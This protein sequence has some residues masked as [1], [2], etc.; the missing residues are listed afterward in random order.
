MS[1]LTTETALRVATAL[2]FA[3]AIINHLLPPKAFAATQLL[4]DYH[5]GITRRGLAGEMINWF[6]SAPISVAEINT[7]SAVISLLGAGALYLFLSRDLRVGTAGYLLMILAFNSFAFASFVGNTGYLDALLLALALL[8]MAALSAASIPGLIARLLIVVVGVMIHENMLP[9]FA[10]LMGLEI[11]LTTGHRRWALLRA[12]AP[13]IAGFLA[14]IV[15]GLFAQNTPDQASA[16]TA[17]LQN[18]AGFTLDVTSTDVSG[19]SIGAN[20]DLMSDM[21]HTKKYWGWVLFDGVPLAIMS[22]WLIWLNLRLLGARGGSLTALLVVG[23]IIAPLSLNIIAFDVVRF[24]VASVLVGFVTLAL[25]CRQIDGAAARLQQTL[26]WP[27]ALIVL[28]LNA[29]IFT[30]QINE[31]SGHVTQFPWIMLR[32]LQWLGP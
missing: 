1:K 14:L 8:G 19:R 30:M 11:W 28:I 21:R 2:S 16:F 24:G 3:L 27:H 7:V 12:G 6:T 25:M 13:V 26:T 18:K 9:Y 22:L 29:N 20:F 5:F 10:T 17:Y 4:Y 23:A 32:Q 31:G 15:I